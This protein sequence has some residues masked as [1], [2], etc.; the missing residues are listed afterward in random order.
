MSRCNLVVESG[1]TKTE[2]AVISESQHQIYSTSGINPTSNKKFP[3]IFTESVELAQFANSVDKIYYYGAGVIDHTTSAKIEQWLLLKFPMAAVE[4]KNDML[5]A[6]RSTANS[7]PAIVSILGTGSNSCVYD[8]TSIID[9]IPS[10]GYAISNEGGGT[11][12]GKAILQAYFYRQMPAK[13]KIK[14]DAKFA[15]TKSQV[16]NDLYQQ[17]NPTAALA[18]YASFIN[19]CDDDAWRKSILSTC[20]KSF[21]E[22]RILTYS[23]YHRYELHFVGS[24]AYFCQDILRDVLEHYNLQAQSIIQKPINGL[25]NWHNKA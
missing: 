11:D 1:S 22:L 8:G 9:N 21:V 24:I 17:P 4:V 16:T 5:A 3:P 20:F 13:V 18:H 6:C 12:I 7:N 10:L 25:I 2:W 19:D 14:F 23:E 15:V